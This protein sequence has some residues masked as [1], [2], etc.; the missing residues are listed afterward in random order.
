MKNK[1]ARR[2]RLELLKNPFVLTLFFT[3]IQLIIASLIA[4]ILFNLIKIEPFNVSTGA[5]IAAATIV[6][7]VYSIIFKEVV[8]KIL[9]IK[10]GSILAILHLIIITIVSIDVG[11]GLENFKDPIS[12]IF[13][14]AQ[15]GDSILIFFLTY[16]S[17]WLGGKI[18]EENLKKRKN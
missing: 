14:L 6:G 10:V 3:I 11:F 17:I 8:P 18:Y 9:R 4:F 16:F 5:S 1:L 13:V 7:W 2:Q 15:L 12:F